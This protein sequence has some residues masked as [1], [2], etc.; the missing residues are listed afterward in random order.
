LNKIY[1]ITNKPPKQLSELFRFVYVCLA[2]GANSVRKR[3][4]GNGLF[5]IV[6]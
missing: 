2:N 6:Y 5:Q 1:T 4:H 3:N